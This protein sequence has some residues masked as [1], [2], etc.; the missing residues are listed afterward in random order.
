[1]HPETIPRSDPITATIPEFVRLSGIGRTRVYE[2]LNAGE[3]EYVEFGRRRLIV[4]GSYR[5]LIER[6]LAQT[7]EPV[8]HEPGDSLGT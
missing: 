6:H 7:S 3:L 5:R 1:M 4:I 2:L 8:P